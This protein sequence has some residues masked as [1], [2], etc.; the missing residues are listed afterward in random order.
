[1]P[2]IVRVPVRSRSLA[3]LGYDPDLQV[4]EAEFKSGDVYRFFMV[5]TSV[6]D[7]L[8][9]S[10]T[11]GADFNRAVRDRFPFVKVV[12]EPPADLTSQ[13]LDSLTR[14]ADPE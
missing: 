9:K 5:P 1:M 14:S 2:E 7:A 4:L 3:S 10:S 11:V 8:S 12:D 13:L 6:H